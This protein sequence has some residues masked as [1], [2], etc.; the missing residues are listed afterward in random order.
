MRPPA[1]A[2]RSP[3][4]SR[5]HLL[6]FAA[7]DLPTLLQRHP[8]APAVTP[9]WTAG[10]F[11]AG[12]ELLG[13]LGS[14]LGGQHRPQSWIEDTRKPALWPPAW[15]FPAVW[16]AVN[17]PA[18]AVATWLV[19]RQRATTPI[20]GALHLFAVG[21]AFN[22]VFLPIVNRAKSRQVYVAMDSVGLVLAL[23][24]TGT[25]ARVA[26]AAAV[27]S[28]QTTVALSSRLLK[29]LYLIK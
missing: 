3:L 25:Y 18:L 17:Y 27:A 4:S 15:A 7:G 11:V 20:A 29:S 12:C 21:L 1:C 8:R 22:V 9:W 28:S 2:A 13:F 14:I 6:L 5:R 10:L 19:W 24:T 16:A 26:P 23:A